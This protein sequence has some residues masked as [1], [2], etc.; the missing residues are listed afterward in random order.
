[1]AARAA[2]AQ[3]PPDPEWAH[4]FGDLPPPS[5]TPRGTLVTMADGHP[6]RVPAFS[7]YD[8]QVH[9]AA[10]TRALANI[11]WDLGPA[12]E[13]AIELVRIAMD[14]NYPGIPVAFVT[15]LLDHEACADAFKAIWLQNGMKLRELL[16]TLGLSPPDSTPASS[17]PSSPPAPTGDTSTHA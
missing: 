12:R 8:L 9:D 16:S 4:P 1:M 17:S 7:F 15:Q 11:N 14:R 10:I 5:R 3:S 13:A 2:H 6:W